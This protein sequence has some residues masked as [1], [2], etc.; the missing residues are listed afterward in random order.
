MTLKINTGSKVEMNLFKTTRL[1]AALAIGTLMGCTEE[2]EI[3]VYQMVPVAVRDI[4]L[5]ASAAGV[6]EPIRTVEVKSKAS[7]EIIDVLAEVGD[8]VGAGDLLVRVDQRI[9][10][11]AVIQAEADL[12]VAQAQLDNAESQLRRSQALY[13]TQSITEQEY[14][15]ARLNRANAYASLVRS[16]RSLEDARIAYED[17]EVRAP[18]AGMIL[19]RNVEV[20]SVIQS[21]S[22]GLSGGQ[23]LLKMA[24][25]DIVQIR[26]LVDETDIGKIEPGLQVTITVDAYPNQ[27]FQGTVLKIEPEAIEQQNVTMFPVLIRIANDQGLMRPGM[28]SEVE[29]HIGS[30]EGVVAVPNA[31]L[32]TQRDVSSAAAVL[33]IEMETVQRQLETAR[34]AQAGGR[35]RAGG[36][37]AQNAQVIA[38]STS[39]NTVSFR[40]QEIQLPT[41]LTAE[42]VNP[43]LQK[44]QSGG[45]QAFQSLTQAERAIMTRIRSAMGGGGQRGQRGQGGQG[46]RGRS[47]RQGQRSGSQFQFGGEYIVFALRDGNP[48]AVPI[49]TGLT[50]LDFS[51]VVRGLDTSDTVLLLPSAGLLQSQQEFQERISRFT[52]GGLTSGGRR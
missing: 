6:V 19:S 13:D 33:G 35:P 24:N 51:E 37:S 23:V 16:Q 21:A 34:Q 15:N 40:G 26:T 3:P 36:D 28:N 25:L 20:G 50:D 7:G 41:G 9:P 5:S 17:T 4:V 1:T 38:A 18:I 27:P 48:T 12:E 43:V 10:R 45:P 29:I 8:E 30:R 2:V 32:R 14:E 22:Q 47:G 39:P 46:G 11:N 42:Q 49:R 31:A 52:G 44:I